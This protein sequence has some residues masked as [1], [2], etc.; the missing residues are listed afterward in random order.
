MSARFIV[1][2]ARHG[3]ICLRDEL[4]GNRMVATF[5]R[6]IERHGKEKADAVG[7]QMAEICAEALNR[8]HEELTKGRGDAG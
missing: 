8:K 3:S 5:Y 1:D 7:Q 6:D 2:R 4:R